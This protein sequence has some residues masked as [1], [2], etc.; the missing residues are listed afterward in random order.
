M[1]L[2]IEPGRYVVAVSGGVD[3]VVLLDLLVKIHNVQL[4]VAHFDHGI[5]ED[6]GE[7]VK[8]VRGLARKYGLQFVYGRGELGAG[9]SEAAAR[10][11][12]YE[13][14][15]GTRRAADAR[16][17]ITAHHKD[18]VLETAILNIIRGTAR[19]GL[20]S[21]VSTSDI[22]R[23]LLHVP[24]AN[25]RAYAVEHGLKWRDDSTN[26]LDTYKR[27]YIRHNILTRFSPEDR[28]RLHDIIVRMRTHNA[29]LDA[30]LE[31]FLLRCVNQGKFIRQLFI[32]LPHTVAREVMATWLRHH[33]V[34]DIDSRMLERLVHAAK[35]FSA[36]QEVHAGRGWSLKVGKKF[37]A[38][39]HNE[40]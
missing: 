37:L 17:V 34:P 23:P 16:A 12:R 5:R 28:E 9:A 30:L 4:I 2:Q 26:A 40:R 1:N 14:L 7:D 21:L 8:F 3:S 31:E 39:K 32:L 33:G 36:G 38:L 20:T 18:D 25:I 6:S 22:L 13:F 29:Q 24:K 35:T 19:R 27:N 11:A 10:K 15:E